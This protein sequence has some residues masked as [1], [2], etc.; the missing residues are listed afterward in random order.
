MPD[1][2][3]KKVAVILNSTSSRAHFVHGMA[4]KLSEEFEAEVFETRFHNDAQSLASRAVEKKFDA[5]IAAG[6]DGTLHQVINGILEGRE[7]IENLPCVGMIPIG[8]GNDFA[9][10][11]KISRD[12]DNIVSRLRTHSVNPIDIGRIDFNE[13]G[14]HRV[15]YFVNEAS[16]GL[17]PEVLQKL[18]GKVKS[19]PGLNYYLAT[20]RAFFSYKPVH[21]RAVTAGWTWESLVRT[22]SVANGQYYGHGLCIAPGA[23]TDDGLLNVFLCGRVSVIDFIR[24]SGRLKKGKHIP[25]AEISYRTTKKIG[26]SCELPCMLEADGEIVGQLPVEISILP[27]K[28]LFL[29]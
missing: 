28:L 5:V 9:R 15:K 21:V 11:M 14:S 26:L 6:G 27:R 17:G 29:K 3:I 24:Y 23:Q 8:S 22:L 20:L 19:L 10:T 25:L 7:H 16:I 18:K 12:Y 4:A 1:P 13:A 2:T